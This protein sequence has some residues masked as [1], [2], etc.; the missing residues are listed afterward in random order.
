MK[1]FTGICTFLTGS[2]TFAPHLRIVLMS[3]NGDF[4]AIASAR[5]RCFCP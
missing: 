3:S 1:I 2:F 4:I 5:S